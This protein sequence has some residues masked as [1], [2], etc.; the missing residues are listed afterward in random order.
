MNIQVALVLLIR[1]CF[2]LLFSSLLF[3]QTPSNS[4]NVGYLDNTL[5]IDRRVDALVSR[6]TLE[7]KA[8]QVV[9]LAAPIP[10]LHVDGYNWWSEALHGV[11]AGVA[12]VFPEPIGMAATFDDPLIHEVAT[13]IS[14]EARGMHNEAVR[15]GSLYMIGLDFW[16]PNLNIFRDPRWGRGQETYG[17]DPYLTSRL[18]VAYITGMQGDN[19]NYLR[20][21]ATPK[22]YAVHSGPE[23]VRRFLDVDVSRHDL[24]DTYLPAFRAAIVE[25]KARSIMCAYNSVDGAPSCASELLLQD[26]LRE[27]WKFDGYVVSDC[28]AV[29]EIFRGH[30]YANSLPEAAAISIKRGTDLDC[31][32]WGKEGPEPNESRAYVEAVRQGLLTEQQLDV[33][34]KRLMRARIALGMF[35]PPDMVPYS[36]IR[37]EA[38]DSEE[39]RQLALRTAR[40]SLVLLKNDGI[41]PLTPDIGRIAVVGP[42]A[43]QTKVLLGNYSGTPSRA[44]SVLDGIRKH[45]PQSKVTF[46]PGTAF[47]RNFIEPVPSAVLFT[48]GKQP[49]LVGQYFRGIDLKGDPALTHTD[50]TISLDSANDVVV[51]AF[52]SENFS[53][54]WNGELIPRSSGAYQL[55][56]AAVDGYRL[57]LDGKLLVEDWKIHPLS[58]QTADVQLVAEHHYA[59][60]LEYFHST[61]GARMQLVWKKP[62][63]ETGLLLQAVNA[64]RASDAVV[65]VVG[66][67]PELEGEEMKI[68]LP[69][70]RGGD[71]TSLDLP[72]AE[73]DLLRAVKAT[74]RPLVVVLMNGSAL[75]VNWAHANAESI[76]D[77]WY[78]GEEGGEAVAQTLAGEN[79]PAGRLPITF[80]KGVDQLPLF[81]DYSMEKRTYRYFDGI[82]LYPFGYGL[83]YSNFAYGSLTLSSSILMAGE[84]L[85]VDTEV[86]NTS[87]RTGD[88]V[89]QLYLHFPSLPGAPLRALR[90]FSRVH[91]GGG[92]SRRVHFDLNPRDLSI[93][94]AG[95]VRHVAAGTYDISVGGGQSGTGAAISHARFTIEGDQVLS[96]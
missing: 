3:A 85:G 40:E 51:S 83:S 78:S 63:R 58:K 76:L 89:V 22:H 59:I 56:V 13:A 25:G 80:Y 38:V 84:M 54:R 65:A 90:G 12:T 5:P 53:V 26:H 10:R 47:L 8:S 87:K 39:H 1:G 7:E 91:L 11:M 46:S 14:V 27:K 68:D 15:N 79:N 29:A 93:V 45:F 18:G 71:R 66:I 88:E 31:N 41:L 73:E 64:A 48:A 61:G 19:P 42:L 43:D 37:P 6:M 9:N 82:P 20:V 52:G 60:A 23:P 44:T 49:G 4:E 17:E 33:A 35:D 75:A 36:Q 74:G 67:T 24:E 70:F 62:A 28:D 95:G 55:G 81:E 77:A 69:G 86:K 2:L 94:D 92:E 21:V 57:W 72:K 32:G 96:Y 16:S 30:H 34:V 50:A